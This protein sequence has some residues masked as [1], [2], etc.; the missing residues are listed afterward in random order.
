VGRLPTTFFHI[1]LFHKIYSIITVSYKG[2][3]II[4]LSENTTLSLTYETMFEG[5]NKF[6]IPVSSVSHFGKSTEFTR[7]KK[8]WVFT[9]LTNLD[10]LS[11]IHNLVYFQFLIQNCK[12]DCWNNQHFWEK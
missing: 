11:N 1:L 2:I 12:Q 6:K 5:P 10:D 7:I 4:K 9:N 3:V 8:I